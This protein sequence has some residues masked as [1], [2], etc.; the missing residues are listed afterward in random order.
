MHRIKLLQVVRY[1]E[2]Q[3]QRRTWK[4]TCF[5]YRSSRSSLAG[6]VPVPIAARSSALQWSA[7]WLK[8]GRSA[9]EWAQHS[10]IT[11]NSSSGQ[12]AGTSGRTSAPSAPRFM[13]SRAMSSKVCPP[14]LLYGSL[15]DTSSDTMMLKA[16]TA[17]TEECVEGLR[18]YVGLDACS[19]STNRRQRHGLW[20]ELGRFFTRFCTSLCTSIFRVRGTLW[21]S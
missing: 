8:V 9:G 16:Y 11:L 1:D 4:L 6:N 15:R 13:T 18:C 3:W 10:R 2:H 5:G 17:Q 21:Q 14:G 20:S 7:S 12:E 19:S